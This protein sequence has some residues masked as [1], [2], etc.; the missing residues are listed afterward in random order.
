MLFCLI[1]SSGYLYY[2]LNK[3]I[4]TEAEIIIK[5][6]K[7]SSVTHIVNT[8][9]QSDL[10]KPGILYKIFIK[11]Y[12]ELTYDK[13]HPGVYK[14][15]P[16]NTNLDII[17]AVFTGKQRY[18][19]RITYPEGITLKDFASITSRHLDTDSS[20][21]ISYCNSPELLTKFKIKAK[22]A[23]G[24]LMPDTYEFFYQTNN[25]DVVAKL[26]TQ[27]RIVLNRIKQKANSKT[28]LSEHEILTLASIVEA[29]TPVIKER[30][31]IAGVYLNRLRIGMKLDADPT[32]QYA[33]GEKRKLKYSDLKINNPYNTYLYKGLPPGPINSPSESSI[34]AVMNPEN[35]QYLFFVSKG[36]GS[37]E[38]YFAVNYPQHL[39]NKVKY[40]RNK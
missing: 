24:Y 8:F 27:N 13:T 4:N 17:K 19:L 36:D 20:E 34:L 16:E 3:K 2:Q 32:I 23:E 31:K 22:S 33:I 40:K 30:P 6:D 25:N 9:N 39:N 7:N 10:L 29:E 18:I 35:H 14:F 37:G 5:I 1:V 12:T 21:F 28:K 38:H 15:S 26:I 11:L